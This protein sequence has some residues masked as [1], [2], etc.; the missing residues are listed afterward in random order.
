VGLHPLADRSWS[1]ASTEAGEVEGPSGLARADLRWRPAAV[2]GTV[3]A[4]LRAC[5]EWDWGHEDEQLLDGRDWWFRCC[6]PHPGED[7]PWD[8]ELDGMA[9]LADVW[10]NGEHLCHSENMFRSQRVPIATLGTENEL[11][12]RCAA[13]TARLAQRHPRPRFKSRLLRHQSLR[14][15][16]TSLLG[17]M[18]GWSRWAAPVGP[19]RPI[20]L[21]PRPPE[22]TIADQDLQARCD[23]SGPGATVSVRLRLEGGSAAV[24]EARLRVGSES[25]TLE[26]SEVDGG[27]ALAGSLAL[28]GVERWWP[29][30]HGAQPLYPVD[31][32]VNGVSRRL[33]RVGFRTIELDRRDGA[34][35]V[36][37]NGRPCFC[38]GVV[39]GGPDAV[40]LAPSDGAVARSLRLA[41][42]AGVN[43]VRL[44]G[45]GIYED[46]RF[47]DACDELG[48]MVWQDCMLASFDPPDDPAFLDSLTGELREQFGALQGRPALTIACASSETYQQGSMYGLAPERYRARCW[49]GASRRS[50]AR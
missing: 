45:F 37:V 9:T 18:P 26:V 29:H 44:G 33:R 38:R 34:F 41:L 35:D 32:E 2:P 39:W 20:R 28:T 23:E 42:A 49:S 4:A 16:R 8:L 36:I 47:W 14:W 21:R 22:G 17:R 6:F 27:V 19:W 48:I 1:C 25:G 7:G 12:I 31:V 40:S 15:Y 50:C 43:M 13:L 5:G 24:R 3:A 10:L 30:T 11:V 46:R